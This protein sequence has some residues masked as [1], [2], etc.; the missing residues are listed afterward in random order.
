M[1]LDAVDIVLLLAGLALLV[2]GAELLVRGASRLALAL[3]VSPLVIGLTVVAFGTSAPELVVSVGGAL[4]GRA[5]LALGNVVGS[6]VFNTLGILG[7]SALVG[8]LVVHQK[9]VR[10][11]VPLV[12][13]VS[14]L[15]LLLA[16][17]GA[18][19]RVEGGVLVAG[20]V[21]YTAWGVA[22]SRREQADVRAEY[23][24]AVGEAPPGS[25]RRWW[26][27]LGLVAAGLG[28]LALGARW[29]VDGAVTLAEV[30]GVSELVIGVTIVAVGTSLP[31]LATSVLAA[32]R[33]Q[34]DIAVGNVVGSNLFNLTAVL[35]GAALVSPGGVAVADAALRLDLPVMLAVAV[36]CL[37][38][39]FTGY[40]I[41]RWEGGL[42]V[43]L[44]LAYTT[45]VVLAA[46]RHAGLDELRLAMLGFVLPL[47]AVTLV[48]VA[49]R[50]LH[51]ARRAARP[52]GWLVVDGNNVM[53]ARADGWWRDPAA[54]A[55][56]LAGDLQ[57]YA[58]G[59][60]QRVLLV[61]D[62]PHPGLGEGTNGGIEVRYARRRG[63]DAADDRIVELLDELDGP[64][65]VVTS[66]RELARRCRSR[67]AT[68]I[69]ARTFLDELAQEGGGTRAPAP[70]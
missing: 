21:A 10:F 39:F 14:A 59:R 4:D 3:G 62:R 6:N 29:L 31:E 53:G 54:A 45:Y 15:V 26:A 43:G 56:R 36:A 25:A 30:A 40:A 37:P 9:L 65:E 44:Y 48:V 64:L 41:E 11:D 60:P 28:A 38:V 46:V 61:L 67:G 70:G 34:R 50:E 7:V 69:G 57:A 51:R 19:G 47:V 35:G 22:V 12:I 18:V 16:L 42:F 8:G 32:V 2:A 52:S 13:G 20:I 63:R 49:G 1:R 23:A 58:R 17:D 68:V 24:A 55:G 27:D 33:G 66:D 5:A